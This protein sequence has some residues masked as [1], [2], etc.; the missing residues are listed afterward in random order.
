MVFECYVV[1]CD[2]LLL[3]MQ[4]SVMEQQQQS[5]DTE[6]SRTVFPAEAKMQ[7]H[8]AGVAA[9]A[10]KSKEARMKRV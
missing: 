10:L 4:Q 1:C 7:R 8:N 2:G 9:A 5:S 3:V 6:L